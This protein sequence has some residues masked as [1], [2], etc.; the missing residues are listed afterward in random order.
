MKTIY[1]SDNL[2]L[3]LCIPT[4][5]RLPLLRE[6]LSAVIDQIDDKI[7]PI[8]EILISNNASTDGTELYVNEMIATNA[9]LQIKYFCNEEN[10]GSDTNIYRLTKQAKGEWLYM[11]SDDDILLPGGLSKL[12]ELIEKY[13]DFDAFSLNSYS[14]E[15]D[16]CIGNNSV[17]DISEDI[18]LTKKDDCLM[19]FSTWLTFISAMAFRRKVIE[20][21]DHHD[22]IGTSLRHCYIYLDA[23]AGGNSLYVVKEN[24]LAVRAN[25]TGGYN[26]FEVF[27]KNFGDV[28]AYA[29]RIGY[30]NVTVESVLIKHGLK[31]LPTWI[32][33]VKSQPMDNKRFDV[34]YQQAVAFVLST[35]QGSIYL[36]LVRIILVSIIILPPGALSLI[37]SILKSIK[38]LLKPLSIERK[39]SNA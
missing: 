37:S 14:F 34:N 30:S 17:F 3:S 19:L 15:K 10:L 22:K 28:L 12:L 4:Y 11:L 27:I 31:F 36:Y 18:V 20:K 26:L 8:V 13:P 35:Y 9:H 16:P 33:C 1:T 39:H 2:I 25:N 24:F 21:N 23:L 5:N 7:A 38:S 6:A 29:T 32:K